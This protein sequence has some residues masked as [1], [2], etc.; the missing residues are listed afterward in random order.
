M[1]MTKAY[2]VVKVL[3]MYFFHNIDCLELSYNRIIIIP[4]IMSEKLTQQILDSIYFEM[5]ECDSLI[6]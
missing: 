2:E 3:L 4:L 1:L 5:L 6:C